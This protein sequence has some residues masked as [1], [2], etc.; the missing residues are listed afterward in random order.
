MQSYA[1]NQVAVANLVNN[2]KDDCLSG[3]RPF[4]VELRNS[5]TSIFYEPNTT[6]LGEPGLFVLCF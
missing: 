2:F 5:N 3:S 6:A 1:Q 4:F